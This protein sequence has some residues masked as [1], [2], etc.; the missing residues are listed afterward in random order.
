MIIYP[1][2][3]K[4]IVSNLSTDEIIHQLKLVTSAP[5]LSKKDI[6]PNSMFLGNVDKDEFNIS[7]KITTPNNFIP[8]IKGLVDPT[9]Q[10][11]IVYIKY[12]LFF[13]S[14]MFLFLWSVVGVLITLFFLFVLKNT[15]YA[16]IAIFFTTV[17]YAITIFYFIKSVDESHSILM[18]ALKKPQLP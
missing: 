9:K 5:A 4:T 17:N 15:T 8:L 7:L 3:E 18:E 14:K 12:E 10:G 13:S 1:V 2:T 6:E 16:A 11:S